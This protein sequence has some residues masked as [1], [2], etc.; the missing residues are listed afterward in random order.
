M[1]PDNFYDTVDRF[2]VFNGN[3]AKFKHFHYRSLTW[4]S[5]KFCLLNSI[6]NYLLFTLQ[7]CKQMIYFHSLRAKINTFA[8]YQL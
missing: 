3:P 6:K 1:F 8:G 2:R 5:L 4:N 7:K